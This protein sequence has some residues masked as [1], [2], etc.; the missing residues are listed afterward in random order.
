M[1]IQFVCQV[2]YFAVPWRTSGYEAIG[3]DSRPA[4]IPGE[5]LNADR[6]TGV[7]TVDA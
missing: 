3:L 2:G 6:T 4:A 5:P 7:F 1:S